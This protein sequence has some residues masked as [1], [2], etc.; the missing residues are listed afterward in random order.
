MLNLELLAVS[1][2]GVSGMS[3]CLKPR[4]P[5]V[6]TPGLVVEMRNLQNSLAE[7][8]LT[9]TIEGAFYVIWFLEDRRGMGCR[10]LDFAFLSNCIK[11]HKDDELERYINGVFDLIFLNY[12]GLG[13]PI[14]NCSIIS[15]ALTGLSKEFF[16]LNKICFMHKSGAEGVQK[17]A[18]SDNRTPLLFNKELYDKNHYFYFNSLRLDVM[19]AK[20]E[21]ISYDIPTVDQISTLQDQFETIKKDTIKTIYEIASRDLKILDRMA[22]YDQKLCA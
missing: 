8:Y 9:N 20:I 5:V 14:I 11:N 18:L 22:R 4:I 16:F 7:K 13:F 17:F 6:I 12:I 19:R 15:R 21:E 1:E 2:I 10:G 3:V